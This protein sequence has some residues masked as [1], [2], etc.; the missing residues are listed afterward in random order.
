MNDAIITKNGINLLNVRCAEEHDKLVAEVERLRRE[1]DV[2]GDI[3]KSYKDEIAVRVDKITH[4]EV[5]ADVKRLKQENEKLKE[6][7]K[8]IN[9]KYED[10]YGI[11]FFCQHDE[12]YKHKLNCEFINLIK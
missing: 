9:E 10:I 5:L 4:I 2:R 3:I 12:D 7:L 6:A 8:R 11:C 1:V